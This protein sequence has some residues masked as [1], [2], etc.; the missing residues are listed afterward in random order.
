MF[1]AH[2]REKRFLLSLVRNP[3]GLFFLT[4]PGRKKKASV[5]HVPRP[6]SC[7]LFFRRSS[8]DIRKLLTARII[9]FV[10]ES[11]FLQYY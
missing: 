11:F 6:T 3:A 10:V 8:T 7:I 9:N 4:N 1:W 2:R 5:C